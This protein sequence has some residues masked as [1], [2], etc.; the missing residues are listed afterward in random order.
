MT[1]A[2]ISVHAVRE[3]HFDQWSELYRGY[4]DYYQVVQTAEMRERVFSWLLDDAH[5]QRG[6]VA[7]MGGPSKLVGLA[8]CRTFSRPLAASHGLFLDDLFV[9][10]ASRGKG[11]ARIL[12]D[13]L[14]SI[15]AEEGGTVVRW[16]TRAHNYRARFLYD[17]VAE[18]TD[19]ITYDMAPAVGGAAR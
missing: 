11:A 3:D 15:A 13:R 14:A 7:A 12:L 1:A 17:E 8:H 18:G 9:D 6:L 10:P 2:D 4:A 16:I 19:W 5:P